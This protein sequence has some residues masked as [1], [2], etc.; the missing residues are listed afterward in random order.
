M[1]I[2]YTLLVDFTKYYYINMIEGQ[3]FLTSYRDKLLAQ[4]NFIK[5]RKKIRDSVSNS[6]L[7]TVLKAIPHYDYR[8]QECKIKSI[9]VMFHKKFS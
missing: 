3:I 9:C 7:F 6:F 5:H 2:K 1:K 4:L 8:S